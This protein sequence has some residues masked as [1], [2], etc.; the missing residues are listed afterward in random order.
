MA[1]FLL[2]FTLRRSDGGGG[3]GTTVLV[4]PEHIVAVMPGRPFSSGYAP[5]GARIVMAAVQKVGAVES[6]LDINVAQ[7]VDEVAQRIREA[8]ET[9]ARDH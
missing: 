1:T 2:E 5:Q 4:N 3:G 8:G 7:S 9:L 6:P